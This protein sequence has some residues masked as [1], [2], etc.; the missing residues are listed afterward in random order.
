MDIPKEPLKN[1]KDLFF[2]PY[3]KM[4]EID[5]LGSSVLLNK[6]NSMVRVAWEELSNQKGFSAF[7]KLR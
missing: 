6:F 1:H 2:S 7:P 5:L 4:L 3:K